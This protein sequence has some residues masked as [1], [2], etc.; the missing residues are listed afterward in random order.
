MNA[1]TGTFLELDERCRPTEHL[2]VHTVPA[3]LA[4]AQV[5]RAPG[6]ESFT[7]VLGDY[8]ITASLLSRFAERVE[9]HAA[10]DLEDTWRDSAPAR[11][12]VRTR[13]DAL[14]RSD[15]IR[16]APRQIR[17]L[18]GS[19][20]PARCTSGCSPLRRSMIWQIFERVT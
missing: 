7:T 6:S 14:L 9:V 2:A 19:E 13:E 12:T 1:T 3:V 11:V 15:T 5:L 18:V 10:A 20:K 8:E 17:M 16:R 4:A